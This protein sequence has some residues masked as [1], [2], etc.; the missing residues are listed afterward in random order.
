[1]GLGLRLLKE[2]Y[3]QTLVR[4][5]RD[6]VACSIH[7]FKTHLCF[8]VAWRPVV[9][10]GRPSCVRVCT[11]CVKS[12]LGIGCDGKKTYNVVVFSYV[13]VYTYLLIQF[14]CLHHY[15]YGFY[16][17]ISVLNTPQAMCIYAIELTDSMNNAACSRDVL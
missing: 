7:C 6:E 11:L 5:V 3:Q 13:I 10:E 9:S 8:E 2:S 12:I 1:M 4:V 17:G 14:C 15:I 16:Y